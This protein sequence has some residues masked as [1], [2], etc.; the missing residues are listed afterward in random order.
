MNELVV[1]CGPPAVGKMTVGQELAKLTGF[2][3]F[4]NHCS[5]E[6][7]H[8]F[9]EFDTASFA[10]LNERIRAEVFEAVAS[11]DLP[12]LVFTYAW[13]FNVASEREVI[14][15]VVARFAPRGAR[16]SFVELAARVDVRLDRNR[17]ESRL[18]AKPSKRDIASS[19]ALLL[20]HD[21]KYRFNTTQEEPFD[22]SERYL[23]LEISNMP[24]SEAAKRISAHFAFETVPRD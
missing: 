6:L 8:L 5:L 1:I 22:L 20:R 17:Q 16:V 9:F 7:A 3:L 14:E 13:A 24:A 12:G 2:K 23:K 11:S 19:G 15:G 18:A 4:H 21:E 10:R